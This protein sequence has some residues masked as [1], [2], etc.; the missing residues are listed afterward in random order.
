MNSNWVSPLFLSSY[1]L[2][3]GGQIKKLHSVYKHVYTYT[4]LENIY[5]NVKKIN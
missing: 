2:N 4:Y 3:A 1:F 5:E